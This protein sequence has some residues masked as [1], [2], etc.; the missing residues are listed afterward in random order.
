MDHGGE[1][2]DK[3]TS[4]AV[5]LKY[6]QDLLWAEGRFIHGPSPHAPLERIAGRR[7]AGGRAHRC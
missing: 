2:A 4:N 6:T 5:G 1:T 3:H 7:H